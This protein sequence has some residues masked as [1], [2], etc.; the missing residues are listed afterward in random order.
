[1][2]NKP[3]SITSIDL[4]HKSERNR[5]AI[6][7]DGTKHALDFN[8]EGITDKGLTFYADVTVILQTWTDL[9]DGQ[10]VLTT[11]LSI[12]RF[13]K[14]TGHVPTPEARKVSGWK[15]SDLTEAELD[16]DEA[17]QEKADWAAE[18]FVNEI[19]YKPDLFAIRDQIKEAA[20]KAH[21]NLR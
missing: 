14:V 9:K 4:S 15:Y 3:A 11:D 2:N 19:G 7:A 17:A 6:W 1:M 13:T 21:F 10:F 18:V 8:I 12:E 5:S 20:F 16:A